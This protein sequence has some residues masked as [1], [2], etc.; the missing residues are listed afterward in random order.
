[1]ISASNEWKEIMCRPIRNRAY[2]SIGIG[3]INQ[4]AQASSKASGNFAYWSYGDVFDETPNTVEYATLEND[5]MKTDGSQF[6]LPENN[7]LMQLKR[8]GIATEEILGDF[9]IDFPEIYS[10][11]GITLEFASAYPVS[12][13]IETKEKTLTYSND[14]PK[15]VAT[16]VLGDTDYIIITPI[17]MVGG[18]QRLRIKS[19]LMGVGLTYSN[20]QTK[21]FN[22]EEHAS[23]I[24]EDLSS[25]V[26]NFSFFDE[27]DRFNVDDDNSFAAFLETMQKVTVSF[28][29]ELD[30][31]VVEWHQIATQYLSEWQ[32][33][34][35][36]VTLKATDRLSQMEDEYTLGN[37]IYQRTAYEEAESIFAD[38]GLEPDE[39]YI[40]DYLNDITLSNPMPVGTHKECLQILANACRCTIRQDAYGI[41]RLFA[42]FAVVLDPE[43]L[44][45]KAENVALWSKPQNIFVGTSVIYADMTQDF[46]KVDG[47]M[48]FLP[49]GNEYLET[50][51]VS[52]EISDIYGLF[53]KNP[54]IEITLP[55][56][57]VYYGININFGGNPPKE[58]TIYTYKNEELCESAKFLDVSKECILFHEFPSFDKMVIEFTKGYPNDRILVNKI[59]FGALSDYVL[60]KT[61]M[62]ENPI[63]Y[64]EKRVK[65]VKCKLFSYIENEKGEPEEVEDEVFRETTIGAVGEVRTIQNPLIGTA[66]HAEMIAEWVGNYYANNTSYDVKF[67]GEPR[68]NAADII[69]ME[70]DRKNNLQVEVVD[71]NLSF[72]GAFSGNLELRRA[73]RT[74]GGG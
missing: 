29:L 14:S 46:L 54:T 8:N 11:K 18:R 15:F 28:G 35:G 51:Y 50:S 34:K 10:I 62:L 41:I 63:G 20:S 58:I 59:S 61:N 40:D 71:C 17:S 65:S 27:E 13:K 23:P 37:R 12:F 60:T 9:R 7:E 73:L 19:A 45:I 55:A 24:S 69:H 4:D 48:Y 56:A 74:I 47:S 64:K 32:V 38:A 5:F 39:Y 25:E 3:I 2:I 44:Q 22:I 53:E 42:N 49:E 68:L 57:Y 43:E 16:D 72:D 67:R 66:E 26:M 21:A 70:S 6:F 30:N 36:T 1:M 52:K 33:Q 31:G